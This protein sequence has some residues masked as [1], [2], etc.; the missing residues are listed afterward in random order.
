MVLPLF[1]SI[2][3]SQNMIGAAG[4]ILKR[5][6]AWLLRWDEGFDR[7]ISSEW[8][9]VIKDEPED[10][11]RFSQNT[12][13]KI[14][15]GDKAFFC[16]KCDA[17]VIVSEGYDVYLAAYERYKTH[18]RILDKD[19]FISA[20]KSL[21]DWTDFWAVRE[22]S[23][24]RLM[25]FSENIHFSNS[26]LYNTIWFHPEGLRR[27]ASYILFHRMNTYYLNT[28]GLNFVSDGTR[29]IS[30]DTHIHEFLES[31]FLFRKAYANLY[32]IYAPWLTIIVH[33]LYPFRTIFNFLPIALC[34]KIVILLE[35][36]RI[37][38][39]CR[40]MLDTSR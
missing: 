4:T 5:N 3:P 33:L 22:R 36:E 15:R 9:H 14:R 17:E 21:P 40:A 13:S 25:A 19:E 23:S 18:E 24:G 20:I 38:R 7:Y 30:H 32:V 12:R 10:I 6:D 29:S 35:Q 28:L 8:W 16:D 27:Y 1:R 26:C 37:Q 31:K 2:S 11:A 39:R 34:K